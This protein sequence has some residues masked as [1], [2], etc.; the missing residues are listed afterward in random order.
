MK[1]KVLLSLVIISVFLMQIAFTGTADYQTE[2]Y[3]SEGGLVISPDALFIPSWKKGYIES[4]MQYKTYVNDKTIDGY[5]LFNCDWD[6]R[7]NSSN[8][9]VDMEGNIVAGFEGIGGGPELINSTTVLTSNGTHMIFWNLANN[10]TSYWALLE[11]VS[12]H[13]D[14]EF[15]PETKEFLFL[16]RENNGTVEVAGKNLTIVHDTIKKV[17][18]NGDVLWEWR[19]YDYVPFNI[20]QYYM[21]NFTSRGGGADW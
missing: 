13:H 5:T 21:Y 14:F 3:S 2:G 20:T 16:D 4:K 9:I 10:K 1:K 11:G 6:R 7:K 18:W 12:F 19:T 17:S 8:I 15:N